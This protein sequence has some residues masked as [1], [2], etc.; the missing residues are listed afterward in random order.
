MAAININ[1]FKT[2]AVDE[3]GEAFGLICLA[4]GT[5]AYQHIDDEYYYTIGFSSDEDL[6]VC[7][8]DEHDGGC[9]ACWQGESPQD[10]L[11]NAVIECC[12]PDAMKQK[13]PV[14][15]LAYDA[16]GFLN[17]GDLPHTKS[18]EEQIERLLAKATEYVDR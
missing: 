18:D 8:I 13:H 16:F 5:T 12:A 9:A 6:W 10:A 11:E 1:E 15:C 3:W 2:T 4:P 17:G 7:E 14:Q